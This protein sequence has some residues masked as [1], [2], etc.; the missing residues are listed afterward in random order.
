MS[1]PTPA[2]GPP[3]K[4]VR[5]QVVSWCLYDFANSAYSAVIAATL[6][7][8]YFTG[9]VVGN[10]TGEGDRWWG[11]AMSLSMALVALSSPVL[12][13]LAD[14]AGLRKRLWIAYTAA[15]VLAV[16]A[17]TTVGPGMVARGFLLVTLANVAME[18]AFVFYNSYLP[19]IA[20]PS[21]QGRVSGWGFATGYLGSIVA[22]GLAFPFARPPF[23][24]EPI[25]LLVAAQF[26]LF[27]LPAFFFLPPDPPA[28]QGALR[29]GAEGVREVWRN[30][31]AVWRD[32][33]A[34]TFLVAYIFY[35]DGVNTV[36]VFASSFAATTL[37]FNEIELL[38]V[39]LLVQV[40]ALAG[41]W[42]LAKPTDTWGPKPI[43]VGALILWCTV[44]T[45]AYFV[46]K[47]GFWVVAVLAGFGLGTV[48]SAS[49]SLFA[50]FVP[51]GKEGQYFGVYALVGKSAA[52]LG[53]LIFGYV[54]VA[55]GSQRPAILS[56]AVLY[57]A[58]LALMSRV[59]V[60]RTPAADA[61]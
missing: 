6:F 43:I 59:R 21:Y 34:R 60:A 38:G 17:M 28:S 45:T 10:A 51:A 61:G 39:F 56:V 48:Q 18:G 58:G 55:L 22:L 20:P 27:S 25:W 50:G 24:P 14:R 2:P 8:K 30:L 36:I 44:V 40:S 31:R 16:A 19:R 57:L 26:A 7:Q 42:A 15:A 32:I 46:D 23:H 1:E 37:G 11:Y 54:S 9:D 52:V 35:E 3:A 4:P 12:G 29:A 53:P 49:R 13:G 33:P 47:R 5:R 41:A